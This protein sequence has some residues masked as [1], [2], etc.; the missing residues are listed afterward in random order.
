MRG[1]R[2]AQGLGDVLVVSSCQ[3]RK[4]RKAGPTQRCNMSDGM[5]GEHAPEWRQEANISPMVAAAEGQNEEP[6]GVW[7]E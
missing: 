5:R 3:V 7:G 1:R 4:D 6:L 2:G